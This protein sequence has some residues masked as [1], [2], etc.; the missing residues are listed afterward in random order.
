MNI[1]SDEEYTEKWN[2]IIENSKKYKVLLQL[3]CM[4]PNTN[5]EKFGGAGVFYFGITKEDL[6]NKKFES[7][8]FA[9]QST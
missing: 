7:T 9:F 5:L 4:D 6:K 3:D 2:E 1:K 8:K